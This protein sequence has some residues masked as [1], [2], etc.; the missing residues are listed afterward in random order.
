MTCPVCSSGSS[1]FHASIDG[2]DYL[3]CGACGSLHVD[4]SV[5]RE[6]DAGTSP[7]LYDEAYWT[8]ELRSAR[9]R[10]TGI[11]LVRTGEAILYATRPVRRFLDIGAGP[12]YLLDELTKQFP[13]MVDLFHGV[14]LFPPDEHTN[15]PNYHIGEIGELNQVFDGGVCIEVVE[16]LTPRMLGGLVSGLAKVSAP[17]SLWLFNTG[18]PDYVLTQ[19]PHYLDPLHRGHIVSYGLRGLMH[20]FE[21][22]GFRISLVPGKNYAFVAEFNPA[23]QKADFEQRFCHPLVENK[24]LLEQSGLMYLAAFE[25]ARSSYYHQEYLAR[26]HWALALQEELKALQATDAA[27]PRRAVKPPR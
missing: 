10:A 2:Y 14:E 20:I 26:T 5:L 27:Q 23:D 12:G 3:Q 11:G 9:E 6:M 16:H 24:A 7:R 13:Q 18:M 8:E 17:G 21:P 1:A 15:H 19:D 4:S 22:H 25:S